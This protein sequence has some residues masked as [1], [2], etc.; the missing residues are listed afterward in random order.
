MSPP[1]GGHDQGPR[2]RVNR[3]LNCHLEQVRDV[4]LGYQDYP[5]ES[6]SRT[7]SN[8]KSTPCR[9]RFAYIK[10]VLVLPGIARI[11]P[12]PGTALPRFRTALFIFAHCF[13]NISSLQHLFQEYQGM[14]KDQNVSSYYL[15]LP[16]SLICV[17]CVAADNLLCLQRS[18]DI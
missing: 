11:Y 13:C 3:V 6:A 18:Y 14:T 15:T 16:S 12:G 10:P 9:T 7:G 4:S 17:Q 2:E 8:N 1:C 5:L